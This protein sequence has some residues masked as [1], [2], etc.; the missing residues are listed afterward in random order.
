MSYVLDTNVVVAALNGH[1]PAVE[2]LN[3][4]SKARVI[5]SGGATSPLAGIRADERRAS[6]TVTLRG[7]TTPEQVMTAWMNSSCPGLR[8]RTPAMNVS[9]SGQ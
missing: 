1:Q 5:T 7:Q 6:V 9:R 4:V 8:E 3:Y 2:R